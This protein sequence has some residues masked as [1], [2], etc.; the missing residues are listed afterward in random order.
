MGR[1]EWFTAAAAAAAAGQTYDEDVVDILS[2]DEETRITG[3]HMQREKRLA[4]L[5]G[6]FVLRHFAQL[7]RF[8][9]LHWP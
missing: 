4:R 5:V 7:T 3:V 1:R 2:D 9:T 6:K 8:L